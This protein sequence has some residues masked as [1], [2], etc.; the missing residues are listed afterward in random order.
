MSEATGDRRISMRATNKPFNID[1]KLVYE[2]TKR[3]NPMVERLEWT[4]RRSSSSRPT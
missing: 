2:A 3:S 1:K 4:V